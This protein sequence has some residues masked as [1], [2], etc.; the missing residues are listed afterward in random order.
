MPQGK[1]RPFTE[2]NIFS[3]A[4]ANSKKVCGGILF[5]FITFYDQINLFLR[6]FPKN[7]ISFRIF[8][9][10]NQCLNDIIQVK[11]MQT[12]KIF[13]HFHTFFEFRYKRQGGH[14]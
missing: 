8:L 7:F 10:T 1:R 13:C 3:Y 6:I 11:S 14:L 5:Q 12:T 9:L 2:K 4:T